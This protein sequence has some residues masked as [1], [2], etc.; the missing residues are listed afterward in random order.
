MWLQ[1]SP[2]EVQPGCPTLGNT[3]IGRMYKSFC[4]THVVAGFDMPSYC[5]GMDMP[6]CWFGLSMMC[7]VASA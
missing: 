2:A 6:S 3:M 1:S 7:A 5:F 4:M